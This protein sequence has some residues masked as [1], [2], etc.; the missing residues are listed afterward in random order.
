MLEPSGQPRVVSLL[1]SATEIVVALGRESQLVGRS[2]ECDFPPSVVDRPACTRSSIDSSRPSAAIDADVRDHLAAALTLYELDVPALAAT[3]PDVILTQSQCEVCAIDQRQVEAELADQLD[4]PARIVSLSPTTLSEVRESFA[5]VAA[6]IGA[7]GSALQMAFDERLARAGR[8]APD[9]VPRVLAVE[10]T[11]PPMSAGNWVPELLAAA[12]A[13]SVLAEIGS[14]SP[15]LTANAIATADPDVLL[16]APCGFDLPRGRREASDVL[17]REPWRSLRA[18]AEGRVYI[19]DGNAY[20]NRS[21]PR[22]A[23]SAVIVAESLAYA[24]GRRE[25]FEFAGVGWS[26]FEAEHPQR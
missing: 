12:G 24:T 4:K 2:H 11:D 18:V 19:A 21:G 22:L 6:A 20:F 23:D 3:Q 5:T 15:Y 13:D 10:W 1:P 17:S 8:G 16:F 7:D 26:P 25:G 14:H 9:R